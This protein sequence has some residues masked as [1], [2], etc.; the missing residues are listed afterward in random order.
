MILKGIIGF[1]R[2]NKTLSAN[3]I[4]GAKPIIVKVQLYLIRGFNY[5]N[6]RL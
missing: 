1:R 5:Q 6:W 4:K 3:A 2:R